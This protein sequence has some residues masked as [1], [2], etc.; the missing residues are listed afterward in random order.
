MKRRLIAYATALVWL[1]SIA[2]AMLLATPA[3]AA[4]A[5][6][7]PVL[8]KARSNSQSIVWT[9]PA[10]VY[11]AN[12]KRL[13]EVLQDFAASQS[14][15]AIIADGVEGVVHGNFDTRP[16]DFLSAIT[17]AYPIV[18]YHDGTALYFYPSRAMQSRMFRLRGFSRKQVE[19]M[20]GSLN[21]GDSRYPLRFTDK[22][23]TLMAYGPPRHI[24]LISAA[25]DSLDTGAT[26]RDR[27]M[28]RVF[29]LRYAS[30]S[31][32]S[33]GRTTVQGMV[34]ILRGI[35][36]GGLNSSE[37]PNA[38]P[39]G[40]NK[41]VNKVQ[42]MRSTF[43]DSRLVPEIR[44]KGGDSISAAAGGGSHAE[45][46][47][48][49]TVPRGLRSPVTDE[50]S[51]WFESDEATN[52]VIVRGRLTRMAEYGYLIRRLDRR[53]ILVELEATI[54]DVNAEKVK[55]LGVDWSVSG[56]KGQFAI[57][58]NRPDFNG[59]AGSA[60]SGGFVMSTLWA[61]AGRELMARVEALRS[62]GQAR[63]VA[64]PKVL[65]VANRPAVMQEKRSA[66]VRV[67]G[68]L[69]AQLYTV[70]AGT[71]LEVTP[72][73]N[74]MD[75]TTRMK[76]SLYIEDGQ[77]ESRVVDGVP[78]VKRTEI[79]TEAH[80]VEGESLLV[81]GI[82]VEADATSGGA[83]PGISRIPVVG[84]LFKWNGTRNSRS[85]RLFLITPKI[86]R[87]ID[88]LPAPNDNQFDPVDSDLAPRKP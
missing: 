77:F 19:D 43:G 21:L 60:G 39:A 58:Q 45:S 59:T 34:T 7:R 68:N 49:G 32:R 41:L 31:D 50:D 26:E 47:T 76:L 64:T 6:A 56:G 8:G 46:P 33:V 62:E 54:I 55:S 81:G 78:V 86:V 11:Q 84:G 69:D 4:T 12:G 44:G 87:D 9:A 42:A 67:S 53:P 3:G 13:G 17:K 83:I 23:K 61:N 29:P 82:T 2:A 25:L 66:A 63:I 52:S 20:L 85:E 10:F 30:A 27:V 51:P 15:P 57:K 22:E 70:E 80:V 35:Y 65:G 1:L 37:S 16:E 5:P 24:E 71:L 79:R 28:V 74:E 48:T 72:Q 40:A 18:W 73:V 36:G 88:H 14:L 38:Q 75:G